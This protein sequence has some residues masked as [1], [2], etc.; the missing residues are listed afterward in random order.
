M[1]VVRHAMPSSERMLSAGLSIL[2]FVAATSAFFALNS[3]Q[4]GHA[5]FEI[6][7]LIALVVLVVRRR[8]ASRR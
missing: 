8:V 1:L 7:M 4:N 5:A 3:R 2:I 6:L